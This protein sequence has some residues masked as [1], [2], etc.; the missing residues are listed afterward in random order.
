MNTLYDIIRNSSDI[1]DEEE[2][3][4]HRDLNSILASA[5]SELGELAQEIAIENKQSYKQPGKDGIV[6]EAIDTLC[7]LLDLIHKYDPD[8]TE[9]DL[10]EIAERKCS[11]WIDKTIQF[12][13]STGGGHWG[14]CCEN[15]MRNWNGGCDNCGDPCL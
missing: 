11:K 3:A 13:E 6:G 5:M 12:N 10:I 14:T 7:C 8:L 15:E 4:Y 2:K 1:M 9:E